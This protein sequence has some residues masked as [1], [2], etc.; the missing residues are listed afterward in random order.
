MRDI[1]FYEDVEFDVIEFLQGLFD[2]QHI[3]PLYPCFYEIVVRSEH[4]ESG[5]CRLRVKPREKRIDLR[6]VDVVVLFDFLAYA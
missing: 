3:V 2:E 5:A 1:D 6:M 4:E